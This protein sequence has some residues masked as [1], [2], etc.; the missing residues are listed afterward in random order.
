MEQSRAKMREAL[1][2]AFVAALASLFVVLLGL[3]LLRHWWQRRG[4][5]P[6]S[7]RGGF[8]LF[9]VCLSD[10]RRQPRAAR[11][12]SSVERSRWRAP[13]ERGDS[14]AAAAVEAEPDECEIARWK[15]IFGGPAR[16]LSTI[17]EGTE[18]GGTTA[19]TT[20]AFCTPPASPDRR[21]ARARPLDMASVAAQLKA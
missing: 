18:K 20:P 2:I 10:D 15:K 5:V 14:E 1:V 4:A 6:A 9:D 19:A 21:E 7:T 3:V 12:P 13:R 11:P 17:D 16:C 8:V